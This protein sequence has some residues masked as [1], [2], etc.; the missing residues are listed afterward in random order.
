MDYDADFDADYDGDDHIDYGGG[1]CDDNDPITS[2]LFDEL[3]DSVDRD[4]DE[5][6]DELNV[7]D[8]YKNYFPI[9]FE[10]SN[11]GA[12]FAPLEDYDGD[13][14]RELLIGS[15][16]GNV[17]SSGGPSDGS[18]YGLD[19]LIQF[20]GSISCFDSLIGFDASIP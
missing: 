6:V 13:G 14:H 1:D 12:S 18:V 7:Y 8:S 16:I 3:W 2:S 17:D 11:L 15:P 9:S 20:I 4:C 5:V 10:L 19:S